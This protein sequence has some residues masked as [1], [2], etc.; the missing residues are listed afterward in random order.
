MQLTRTEKER[1]ADSRNKIQSVAKSLSKVDPEKVE[2][3]DGIQDCLEG[4][5][6]NLDKALRSADL[7]EKDPKRN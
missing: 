1:I 2:D 7:P 3:I 5:E 4:A 6:K